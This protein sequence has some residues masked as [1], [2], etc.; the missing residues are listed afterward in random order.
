MKKSILIILA[1]AAMA[2]ACTKFAEDKPI[3]FDNAKA[4]AVTITTVSDESVEVTI[5]AAEGTSFFAYAVI[6]G[7]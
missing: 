4:P 3:V 1:G 7:A 2:A 6:E 5:A